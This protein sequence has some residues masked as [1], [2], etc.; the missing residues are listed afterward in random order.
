MP[1]T[2]S[3]NLCCYNSERYLRETME[4]I[5]NQTYKD[6]EL[7][8]IND[9]SSDST[10]SIINEYITQ[11]YPIIYY[12]QQNKGLGYSRNEALKRS[13]GEYIAFID[14]DDLWMP[15]KLEKQIPLFDDPEVGLV[16]SDVIHFNSNNDEFRISDGLA[17]YRGMCFHQLLKN[18]FLSLPSVV[19]RKKILEQE[20][21]WF[22]QRFNLIEEYDFFIR[23]AY[24]WKLDMCRDA[25]AKYRVHKSSCSWTQEDL[26]YE[27]QIILLEKYCKLWPDFSAKY[28]NLIKTQ[29]Y[30]QKALYLW[31]NKKAKDARNCLSPYWYRHYKAFLL[32]LA[33]FFPPVY[34]YRITDKF[35]KVT[36]PEIFSST[37]VDL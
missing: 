4:S 36:R 25:L 1:P 27:E 29:T 8:I 37:N 24:S 14:H 23:I 18:Y 3:I 12:Y 26:F 30:C 16:Y 21:E 17:F 32:Y 2:V 35:R 13:G 7:V 33:S 9:G 11:G 6:W 22:D 15:G 5:V 34:I 20:T 19:I 10:E 31:K 28:F